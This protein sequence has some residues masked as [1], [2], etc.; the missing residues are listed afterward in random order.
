[1]FSSIEFTCLASAL[2]SFF[3]ILLR[4]AFQEDNKRLSHEQQL[5]RSLNNINSQLGRI[6]SQTKR[7]AEC[8]EA[9]LRFAAE[10][11]AFSIQQEEAGIISPPHSE[12]EEE[13]EEPLS[14]FNLNNSS[15]E[16]PLEETM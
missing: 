12:E 9:I 11:V 5:V 7:Q 8:N 15:Q 10:A 1:M 14:R 4:L 3:Y 13:E 6:A 16:T 2:V